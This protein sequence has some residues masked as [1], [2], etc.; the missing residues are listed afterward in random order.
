[1]RSRPNPNRNMKIPRTSKTSRLTAGF[2]LIELSFVM[3]LMVGLCVGIGTGVGAVQKWK[4]GKNGSLALQAVYA[5]QRAYMAD[6]PTADIGD[7]T[8]AQLQAYLPQGWSTMPTVVGLSG[9]SLTVDFSIMP[10]KLLSGSTPY[11]P[12]GKTDDGL[13]DTGE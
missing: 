8:S 1:M 12:S 6:H 3:V 5:A 2:S 10:P 11:D 4:K 7:V 13:W 9:E